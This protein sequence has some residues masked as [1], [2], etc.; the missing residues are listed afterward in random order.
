MLFGGYDVDSDSAW[1]CLGLI[2]W[3]STVRSL[4]GMLS[5]LFGEKN[6]R[7]EQ[8]PWYGHNNHLQKTAGNDLEGRKLRPLTKLDI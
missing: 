7:E 2:L 5:S 1:A 3:F 6:E 4:V 8:F